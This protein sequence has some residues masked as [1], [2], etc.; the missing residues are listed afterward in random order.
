MFLQASVFFKLFFVVYV[1]LVKGMNSLISTEDSPNERT[2]RDGGV[3]D[4]GGLSST[5]AQARIGSALTGS[6]W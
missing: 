2:I 5:C 6:D 4:T 3:G 1:V